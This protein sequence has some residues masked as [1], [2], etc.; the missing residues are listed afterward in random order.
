MSKRFITQAIIPIISRDGKAT[1][2]AENGIFP[3]NETGF[4]RLS[5]ESMLIVTKNYLDYTK[6]YKHESKNSS[7]DPHRHGVADL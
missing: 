6:E 3:P 5:R 4:F 7:G 2:G 1:Y